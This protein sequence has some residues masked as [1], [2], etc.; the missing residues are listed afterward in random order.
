M[1]CQDNKDGSCSVEYVP[2]AAGDYDVN[3]TFGGRPIPGSPFRVRVSEPVDASQVRCSGAGLGPTVRA[4]LPHSVNVDCSAA[5]RAALD[6]TLLGPTGTPEPVEVR[7]NGDGTHSVTY[8]PTAVGPHS[9]SIAYGG[10][11]V[12]RSPFKLQAVPPHDASRVLASGPGLS[13]SGVPASLPV[14]FAIDARGAG[15]GVL[16]VQILDPEGRPTEASIEDHGDGTFTVRYLPRLV[17]RYSITVRYGGDDIPASPFCIHAAPSGDA[18]KCH[19][20]VSIGGH[21]LG[22]CAFPTLRPGERTLLAVDAR[23]AGPG[24]VTCSVLS[25]DGAE[26]DVDVAENPDGTFHVSYTAPEPGSYGLTVRF[27]GQHVPNSPFRIV[28]TAEPPTPPESLRPFSLDLPCA[29]LKGDITAEVRTPSGRTARAEVAQSG[30]GTVAVRFE[31]SEKGR[32]LMELRC[33]GDPLPG[34]P[35]Q[36]YVDAVDARHVSAYGAGLSHGVVN[37]ACSFTVITKG[38]GEGGLSL[39]VEGPSK[40]EL[41]CHD[42]HD[43]TCTVSYV[44][45]APGD[46]SVIVRFDDEHIPG[47]P[48]TA[49]ITGD[50]SLR[51]S[52]LNVGT[53]TDVSLKISETD[54][55]QLTA[56]IRAP[57]GSEEP[58]LLKRLPNRHIGISFTPKEVGEH[59]VSVR[60]GGQHVT[61]SPFKIVVGPS[62]IGN[63]ERVKVWGAGLS[64]GRT[65]QLAHF[66]VDTRS[67]GYGGLGLSVE[68]PSKVDIHCED[69]EDGTCK[70]SYCPTEPGS[71]RLS[72]KFAERHVPGSPFTVKVSGEGRVKESITRARQAASIAAIG[73]A[74]DLNLKIPGNWFQMVSAQERLTRTFTRSSHTYTR[75]ERTEISK[76]RGGETTREVRVQESTRVGAEPFHGVFGGFLG[77]FGAAARGQE[78]AAPPELTAQVLSPSGQRS[79]AEV[80]AGPGGAYRVRFVPE[81]LG[82]HSV[83]VK[84]RGQHVPGS[85][86]PFTVGPLGEGGAHRARA[87]G[88]GLQ[89]GVA[90][91]PA[92]FSIWTR[93]AG[94]GGLSIAVEGPS[95]AEINFE[96]RKDGSCGVTY[97]VQEPGDY[98]VSIKFNEEHIPDSPFVVPVASRSD[99]AQRITVSSAQEALRVNHPAALSVHLNGARGAIDAKVL[100]PAGTVSECSVSEIDPDLYS[101]GFLPVEN[102]VH[103]VEVRLNGRHVPGSPFNVRVGEQ[104]HDADPGLVTAYGAGL[105]GGVTG[106]RSEFVVKTANAGAGALSVTIDGPSKV[107]LDCVECAEGHRITYTPMAPGNYLI[108]IKYGGPHHIVGS[109]FKAKVTGPRLSGGH[110]LHETSSVLVETVTR[111]ARG[112]PGFGTLPKF[113]SDAS[114]VVARGPGLSTAFVG[115]KNHFT[116]DCS[117]AGSN[118]LMVGVHGP[119]TP[120]EEVY[121]KHV[122][123]R[124]YNVTY[125][126]KEKG[127]YVL[128]LRWGDDSVPGSPFRVTVP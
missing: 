124:L 120:C 37:K 112:P 28:A 39:A 81:E 101:I 57:S 89:R 54:L 104:S 7:D 30:D 115:Q 45:T 77:G 41:S 51:T 56:S 10:Q 49:K 96:D 53:A 33:D 79:E 111:G 98:E 122:G 27:G 31:P 23:A 71:Y 67:A 50:D 44:P 117:K 121:V 43:G 60:K 107:T 103:A 126:V 11:E 100:S 55:S 59:V 17:G 46:Y 64:E 21:G 114:K 40:A 69:A 14:E 87:G 62:E 110:S 84:F 70:V 66:V 52:Q 3:I 127:E 48:F 102:G 12:P 5:G 113:S 109:P 19:V 32:H 22:G 92:E 24:K 2:F 97:L 82:P 85:P 91:V 63:A 8:S 105:Q 47:S 106:V 26:V 74:C 9:L 36:F 119:K 99:A 118:M 78:D 1:S 83:A 86:F 116:V 93:E 13:P 123:N 42:N 61:N 29:P 125:T 108:S 95:K 15:Q 73:S 35:L 25:P 88:P 58:C 76:T 34:S 38:A 18:S 90:G 16:T 68:G 75:T 6:V 128:I 20:T 72:V 94:A 65:F 4:R 80:Q